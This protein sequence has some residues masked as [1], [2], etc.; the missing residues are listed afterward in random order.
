M[1]KLGDRLRSLRI[2]ENLT[3]EE[4]AKKFKLSRS[5]IAMYE[6]NNRTPELETLEKYADYFNVDMNYITGSTTEEYYHDLQTK[7]IAQEIFENE[8]LRALFDASR[9]ATAGDLKIV[10]DLLIKLVDRNRG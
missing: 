1:G 6:Q 2:R 3:Q 8:D 4:L 10:R 9:G 5:S 7:Q